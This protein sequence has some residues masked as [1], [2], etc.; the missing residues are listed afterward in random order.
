M[1]PYRGVHPTL[2]DDVF[3]AP[4]AV[5]IGDVE[6]GPGSSIWYNSVVRGDVGG[7]RIGA[8]ANLQDGTVVHVT[9]GAF[10]TFIG[11]EV[12]V[13]HRCVLHGCRLEARAFIGMNATVLDGCVVEGDAMLAAGAL[14]TPG[15][16]LPTGEVWAGSPAKRMRNLD[17]SELEGFRRQT[18]HYAENAQAHIQSLKGLRNAG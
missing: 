17:G 8:G 14:L 10:D 11:D 2:A 13:G 15:K 18:A 3:I 6:I 4:G 1:L 12:L 16:R 7:I 5:V 9:N